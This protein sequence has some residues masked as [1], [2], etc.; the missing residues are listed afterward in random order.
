M[1]KVNLFIKYLLV[2]T[3]VSIFTSGC[4]DDDG[5]LAPIIPPTTS[6][7]LNVLIL[8]EGD[9]GYNNAGLSY[10]NPATGNTIA[11]I[12]NKQLGAIAQNMA[13]YGNKLYIAVSESNIISVIEKT[14]LIEI[15]KIEMKVEG[16]RSLAPRYIETYDGKIYVTCQESGSEDA[17][18]NGYV[19]RIDTTSLKIEAY[20]KVGLDPEDLTAYEGKL[21]VA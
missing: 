14:H 21:Y 19:M 12:Y 18:R 10:Y 6:Q 4:N 17:P 5:P 13:L 20:T 7:Q 16:L 15:D 11:D 9:W 2:L 8:N 1:K 3:V